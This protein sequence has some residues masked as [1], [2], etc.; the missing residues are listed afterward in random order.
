MQDQILHQVW[1]KYYSQQ[2]KCYYQNN[3]Y[4]HQWRADQYSIQIIQPMDGTT[5]RKYNLNYW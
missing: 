5:K 3:S 2:N 1:N 4:Y